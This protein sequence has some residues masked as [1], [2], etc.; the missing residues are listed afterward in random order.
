VREAINR[1]RGVAAPG[2]DG[3]AGGARVLPAGE[4]A[5]L[6]DVGSQEAAHRLRQRVL[7]G[8]LQGV[9]EVIVGAQTVL[10]EVD[11]D[12]V[13]LAQL[14]ER[15]AGWAGDVL[16]P[17]TEATVGPSAARPVPAGPSASAYPEAGC[18]GHLPAV[19]IP[20]VYDG[21]DLE[22]VAQEVGMAPEEVA[23]RH[24]SG[25]YTVGFMGFSPGFG[26]LDGLDESLWVPR[27][28]SPRQR[29]PAGSVAM[30]GR[31]TAVYPQATPGG[32]RLL[33]RTD[34]CLF[35]P[36]TSPPT[37]L[38]P[39]RR[40][41]FVR[42]YEL[43]G[44]LGE[45]Q[46]A[47]A[48]GRGSEQAAGR[49]L[50][51]LQPGSLTTVQDLGRFG[52]AHL[53]VPQAG[54]ADPGALALANR[55]VGNSPEMA[56]LE[57]TL[58]GPDLQATAELEVA[59]AGA[60]VP[61]AVDGRPVAMGQPFSVL[62]GQ[63]LSIGMAKE[64]LRSYLAVAGGLDVAPVLGS[65]S[66]DTLAGLGPPVVAPGTWLPVGEGSVPGGA[67]GSPGSGTAGSSGGGRGPLGLTGSS[68]RRWERQGAGSQG[69]AGVWPG[70]RRD[71]FG[72]EGWEV[73]VSSS[74]TVTPHSDRTGA[75]LSGPRIERAPGLVGEELPPEGMV[76]GAIQVPPSGQPVVL[77][78]NHPAT[79]G[80]P[81]IAVIAL[82][83]LPTLAQARP[84]DHVTFTEAGRLPV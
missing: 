28:A 43:A 31:H 12:Q 29:V 83:D 59:L 58:K 13:D 20:V 54:A 76:L 47:E 65:R 3:L 1:V 37:P 16:W 26:Y 30:A 72:D 39:G 77:L 4:A 75:R 6:V 15:L 23:A 81:V 60:G 53:G 55:L 80:Y 5:L 71:W 22:A 34:R 18:E 14:G 49:G 69:E 78:A 10:V 56:G 27:L 38:A 32:W 36:A 57:I 19:E 44:G 70:P 52:W 68:G 46:P 61:A 84:G 51:V 67:G 33:G 50:R 79:G 21:P 64:G 24:A 35:D 73:L 40:V 11:P 62:A 8:G 9:V 41:R 74:W 17:R 25:E 2:G 42:V 45:S 66:T 7:A 82:A 63:I 48:A